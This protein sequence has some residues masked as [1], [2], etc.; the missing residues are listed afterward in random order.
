MAH[1]IVWTVVNKLST[2]NSSVY[3]CVFE[4]G[5][6][7]WCNRRRVPRWLHV[8]FQLFGLLAKS[9]RFMTLSPTLVLI[10]PRLMLSALFVFFSFSFVFIL[11]QK[12]ILK[13]NY[14]TKALE[15]IWPQYPDH[16][17]PIKAFQALLWLLMRGCFKNLTDLF[18]H[19]RCRFPECVTLNL[20]TIFV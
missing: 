7:N 19:K 12:V 1:L 4:V 20:I 11:C 13:I 15:C 8:P 18:V 5:E 6:A 17:S 10:R 2:R 14:I 9:R 3:I 16:F